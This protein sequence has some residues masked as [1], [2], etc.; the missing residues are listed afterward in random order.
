MWAGKFSVKFGRCRMSRIGKLPIK[1]EKD[2]EVKVSPENTITVKAGKNTI[3]VAVKPVIKV[4][5]ED[6]QVI[7][8]RENDEP[9]T[10]AYHGLYRSLID[11]AVQGVSKGWSKELELN[12]VGYKAAVKGKVLELNLGYSHPIKFDIPAGIE[13][14]VDKNT[15]VIV[16]GAD[17]ALVGQV[18]AE[19]RGFRPP[20]PYL[21]KGVKYSD[22]HIRRKAGKS[23]AK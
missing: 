17:K 7:L 23:A 3:A 2:V 6:G 15:K 10:K 18:S 1:L 9:R 19:I 14:K 22:E 21:G 13:I 5:V 8:T 4:A 11:N 16:N 20:E 12:G